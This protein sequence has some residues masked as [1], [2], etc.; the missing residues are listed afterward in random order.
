MPLNF[1]ALGRNV[2]M[3][4]HNHVKTGVVG[5]VFGHLPISFIWQFPG[6]EPFKVV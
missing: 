4:R 5:L 3:A 2:V 6:L 1:D